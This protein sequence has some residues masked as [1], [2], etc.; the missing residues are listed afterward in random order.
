MPP[1]QSRQRSRPR[2]GNMRWDAKNIAAVTGLV[3]VL[4]QGGEA[5]LATARVEAKVDRA[6]ERITQLERSGHYARIDD[7]GR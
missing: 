4:M 3:A 6:L 5:R 7:D 2:A 1:K